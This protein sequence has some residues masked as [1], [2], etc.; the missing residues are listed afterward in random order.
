MRKAEFYVPKEAMPEFVLEMTD[1]KLENTI[2]GVSEDDE[3]IIEVEYEK[4][5][6]DDVDE[7]ESLL[8]KLVDKFKEE[9]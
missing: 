6:S 7:L 1:R 4:D 3:I 8:E 2:S 9:E 5:D